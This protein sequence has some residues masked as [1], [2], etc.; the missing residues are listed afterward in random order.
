MSDELMDPSEW[1]AEAQAITVGTKNKV[2]HL[3]GDASL[4]VYHNVDSWSAWCWRCHSRGWVP[5]AQPNM[6]ERLARKEQQ[7]NIDNELSYQ[8]RPPFPASHDLTTWTPAA[9][10]WLYK[11]GLN[12]AAIK[13]LGAYY[14]EPTGRVVLPIYGDGAERKAIFW[15]ARNPEYPKAGGAKYISASVPRDRVHVLYRGAAGCNAVCLT[16]DI[17]SAF[18]VG[19]S[20]TADGYA[21]M[22]T[23]LSQHTIARLLQTTARIYLWFDPDR[24]GEDACLSITKQLELVGLEPLRITTDKDPKAYSLAEIRSIIHGVRSHAA[25]D[26]ARAEEVLS[27]PADAQ[28]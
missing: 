15:Q 26:H 22:G 2:Q 16:E 12:A 4:V 11:A 10:L 17:L 25:T 5:K 18:K 14:H 3:C 24:A 8:V 20:G 7:R 28:P 21:V 9:R 19:E 6:R 1:L 23:S 27:A 13:R